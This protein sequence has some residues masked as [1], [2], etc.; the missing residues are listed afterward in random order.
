MT[1]RAANTPIDWEEEAERLA[2]RSLAAD[3]PT[4]WFDQ[5]YAAGA[6][7]RVQ[8]P[9]SR[10]RPHPLLVELN[11]P[12]PLRREEIEAFATDGLTLE[13]IEIVR[14]AE[15]PSEQRWRAELGRE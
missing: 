6:S 10:T 9:W 1:E 2:A 4:A 5:L 14:A 13:R 3:D 7:G 12:W 8:M 11:P 15:H